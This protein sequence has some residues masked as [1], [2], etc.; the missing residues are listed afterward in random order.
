[1]A[2][3]DSPWD[4]LPQIIKS[5]SFT[6]SIHNPETT[7]KI[8]FKISYCVIKHLNLFFVP[9]I[10]EERIFIQALFQPFVFRVS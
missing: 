4:Q 5:V 3:G 10:Q 8:T 7:K 6:T 1:M 2:G 9:N